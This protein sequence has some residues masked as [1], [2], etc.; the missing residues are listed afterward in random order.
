MSATEITERLNLEAR[1]RHSQRME[2]IGQLAAGVAHDFNNLLTVMMGFAGQARDALSASDPARADL[3]EV[4]EAV[5]FACAD[6]LNLEV[7][8]IFFDTTSTYFEVDAAV[9]APKSELEADG[10]LIEIGDCKLGEEV[11]RVDH[12][13]ELG[14][15]ESAR[16]IPLA[17]R[18]AEQLLVPLER[19]GVVISTEARAE[20]FP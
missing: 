5:F 7:D 3:A 18:V 14:W 16:A 12:L 4:Q 8:V 10:G 19:H 17:K 13:H 9:V 11:V 20:L 15:L 6:L 1:L 2:P